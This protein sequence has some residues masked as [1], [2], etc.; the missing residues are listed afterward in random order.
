MKK[1][2]VLSKDS[3]GNFFVYKSNE[4]QYKL[5]IQE[6]VLMVSANKDDV[7]NRARLIINHKIKVLTESLD[8][9]ENY[10]GE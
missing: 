1:Y 2:F 4:S 6:N 10:K 7:T 8:F 9:I 5:D 3:F